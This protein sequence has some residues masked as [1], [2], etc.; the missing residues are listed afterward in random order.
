MD[1]TSRF[2]HDEPMLKGIRLLRHF[3]IFLLLTVAVVWTGCSPPPPPPGASFKMTPG[4]R[5]KWK[6]LCST[7][8]GLFG[9]GDGAAGMKLKPRPRDF[10]DPEWQASVTDE[11]LAKIIVEGGLAVGKSKDMPS[12][13]DLKTRAADLRSLVAKI[14]SF[15]PRKHRKNPAKPQGSKPPAPTKK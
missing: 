11:Y 9:K 5:F 10:A 8:H 15:V 7:C 14:R 6:T 1:V 2:V 3:T 12:N 4:A 13:P